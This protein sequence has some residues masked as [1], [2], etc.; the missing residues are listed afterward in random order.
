MDSELDQKVRELKERLERGDYVVEPDKVADAILRRS[1]DLAA[2]RSHYRAVQSECS[3]PEDGGVEP[4]KLTSW[5]PWLARPIQLIGV[6]LASLRNA[7]SIAPR[8]AG[9]AHTQSS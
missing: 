3:Y 9:G 2:I 5:A 4:S 6:A 1:R 7:A 8:A